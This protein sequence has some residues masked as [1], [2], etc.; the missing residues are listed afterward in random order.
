[1]KVKKLFST[2]FYIS[3]FCLLMAPGCSTA[4]ILKMPKS[5]PPIVKEYKH[6]TIYGNRSGMLDTGIYLN[7]KNPFS[8][9]ATGTIDRKYWKNRFI[10]P[11]DGWPL[12]ARIGKEN[13]RT[14]P[15]WRRTNASMLYF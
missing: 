15:M 11:E 9:L 12:I 5:L 8:I 3:L 7:E 4:P 10:K 13:Q 14:N 1:M 6:I 2:R